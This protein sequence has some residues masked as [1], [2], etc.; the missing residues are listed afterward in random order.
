MLCQVEASSMSADGMLSGWKED[1]NLQ[2][3]SIG[4]FDCNCETSGEF[5]SPSY[6]NLSFVWDYVHPQF[7]EDEQG[8][9]SAL[10]LRPED[11]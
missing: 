9:N 3:C 7:Y 2:H 11:A 4:N 10:G 6:L 1:L 8:S 5:G